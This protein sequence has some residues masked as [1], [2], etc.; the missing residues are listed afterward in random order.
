MIAKTKDRNPSLSIRLTY[1]E[2]RKFERAAERCSRKLSQWARVV[3]H[4]A[5]VQPEQPDRKK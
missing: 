3:L 2:R 4:N 5:A 1:A